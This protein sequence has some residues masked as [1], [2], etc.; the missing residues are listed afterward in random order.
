MRLSRPRSNLARFLPYDTNR[1]GD[2]MTLTDIRPEYSVA[3]VFSRRDNNVEV[4]LDLLF[5]Q[6]QVFRTPV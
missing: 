1:V 2:Y 6:W 5:L 3:R 4:C